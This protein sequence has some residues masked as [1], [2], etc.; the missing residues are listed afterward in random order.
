MNYNT[1]VMRARI[2]LLLWLIGIIF[3]MAWIGRFSPAYQQVFNSIFR[4]DWMHV[5]MHAILFA[6][7]V[8]ILIYIFRPAFNLRTVLVI[9]L[10][11]L[12]IGFLQEGFQLASQN[13]LAI[14]ATMM[15]PLLFDLSVDLA[16]G[17]LG[18]AMLWTLNKG[19]V[20]L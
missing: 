10:F 6:T 17:F 12:G 4:A 18:L 16:G 15:R 19:R 3:P 7:L 20:R 14:Q 2:G 5:L 8:I 1:L 9:S 13:K 11:V